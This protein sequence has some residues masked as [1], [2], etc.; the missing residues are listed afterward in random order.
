MGEDL[1]LGYQKKVQHFLWRAYDNDI[2][3]GASLIWR[4]IRMD[5]ICLQCG[6]HM[7]TVEHLFFHCPKSQLIWKL[8]PVSWEGLNH[9]TDSFSAWW[10]DQGKAGN[11]KGLLERQELTA[12]IQWQMWKAINALY[13]YRENWAEEEIIKR[14]CPEWQEWKS[15]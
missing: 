9:A 3:V 1:G 7:E 4:G 5:G 15:M 10:M 12:F 2:P 11:E 6:E 13:F 14:A 8:A